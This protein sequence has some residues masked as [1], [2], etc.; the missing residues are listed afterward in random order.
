MSWKAASE[1]HMPRS[2]ELLVMSVA[3]LL[4]AVPRFF[5]VAVVAYAAFPGLCRQNALEVIGSTLLA[6][7]KLFK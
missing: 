7:G 2:H 1:I 3:A 6:L 5:Y 4:D